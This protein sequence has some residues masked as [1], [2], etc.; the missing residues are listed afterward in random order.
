MTK[1]KTR[2]YKD[3]GV[4]LEPAEVAKLKKMAHFLVHEIDPGRTEEAEEAGLAHSDYFFIRL[5]H[6]IQALLEGDALGMLIAA[7]RLQE[8][9]ADFQPDEEGEG[10]DQ[11]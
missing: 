2:T 5:G 7:E 9:A 10:D 3:L 8:V 6:A 1:A 4:I 11:P